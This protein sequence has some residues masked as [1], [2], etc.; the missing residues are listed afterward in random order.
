MKALSALV[1]TTAVVLSAKAQANTSLQF[2]IGYRSDDIHW[3]H[4]VP[5]DVRLQTKTKLTFKD[6]EIFQIGAK[7][8]STCGECVY[9]R[10]DAHY[11]WITDGDVRESDQIAKHSE[12]ALSPST[13]TCVINPVL[14][15]DAKNKYTADFN[16]GFGYPLEQCWCPGLQLVP[17]LG[18]EYDRIRIN[19]KNHETLVSVLGN[20]KISEFDLQPRC[21]TENTGDTCS[22]SSSSSSTSGCFGS[23]A[24]NKYEMT[25]WGPWIGFDLA[26][27]HQ[28]CWNMYAEVQFQFARIRRQ[29]NSCNVGLN[30]I[31]HY[32]RT[33]S[34]F[35]F[36]A[37]VGSLYFFRCNWFMDGNI[38]YKRWYSD[39]SRDHLTWRQV[40]VG[41]GIGYMF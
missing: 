17:T 21:G 37:K 5:D 29:R 36:S 3:N 2:E 22:S 6:L 39:R 4:R 18:F 1:F 41:L 40:G 19:S 25:V 32:R 26:Y 12:K 31:D 30:D 8:K 27:C 7:L 35:G 14:H 10:L 9:Y 28:E 24:N 23:N 33:R 16:V 13:V 15:N 11:G 38:Y 20:D 34:A